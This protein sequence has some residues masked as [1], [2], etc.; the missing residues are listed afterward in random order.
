[1]SGEEG[2]EIRGNRYDAEFYVRLDL[3][4]ARRLEEQSEAMASSTDGFPFCACS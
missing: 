2:D 1:M 3:E 4:Q